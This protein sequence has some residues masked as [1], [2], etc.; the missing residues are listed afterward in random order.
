MN[1]ESN[2]KEITYSSK[3]PFEEKEAIF[4]IYILFCI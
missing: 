1:I 2:K 3:I 4:W